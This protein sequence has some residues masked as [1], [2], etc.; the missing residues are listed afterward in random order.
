[1]FVGQNRVR[2]FFDLFRRFKISFV[3][4]IVIVF[5]IIRRV[6][7]TNGRPSIVNSAT[8]IVHQVFARCVDQQVPSVAFGKDAG[9]IMQ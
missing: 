5:T 9:T 4:P 2:I 3:R 8:M 1:M 6:F 7:T